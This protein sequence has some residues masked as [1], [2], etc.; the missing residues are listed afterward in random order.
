M[1][2]SKTD[3]QKNNVTLLDV[4]HRCM[5]PVATK[6]ERASFRE[7]ARPGAAAKKQAASGGDGGGGAAEASGS[8]FLVRAQKLD[9]RLIRRI[10]NFRGRGA[11]GG[12]CISRLF[13]QLLRPPTNTP[14]EGARKRGV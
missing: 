6:D 1:R 9:V 5:L 7:V 13:A 14:E 3:L 2:G 4:A 10:D 8:S 11:R 12:N